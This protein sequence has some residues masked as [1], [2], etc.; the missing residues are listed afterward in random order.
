[1]DKTLEE[2]LVEQCAPT[3]AG[4]KTGSLL[5]CPYG[6][7]QEML[8]NLR[9][10]NRRLGKKGLRVIPLRVRENRALDYVYRPEK[11][12]SDLENAEAD[13]L[14]REKYYPSGNA[15]KCVAELVRRFRSQGGFPHEIGLFLGYEPED[16]DGFIHLGPGKAK[17]SGMWKIYGDTEKAKKRFDVY[18]KCTK[19]YQDAYTRHNSIDRLVVASHS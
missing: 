19:L 15:D 4:L 9:A 1:M 11:L 17:Y 13:A 5:T 3:L 14:L 18:R 7:T 8:G 2:M 16:V 6:S 10:W 12:K